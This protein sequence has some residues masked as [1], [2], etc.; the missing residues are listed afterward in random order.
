[1]NAA[2]SKLKLHASVKANFCGGMS[3][4][5][6]RTTASVKTVSAIAATLPVDAI[7]SGAPCG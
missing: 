5:V 1:M 6:K 3:E 2:S 4:M 7:K